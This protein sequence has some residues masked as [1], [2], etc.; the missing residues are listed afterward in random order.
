[1][2]NISYYEPYF[3]CNCHELAGIT[4]EK[5]LPSQLVSPF[6]FN[7]GQSCIPINVK[8]IKEKKKDLSF[9]TKFKTIK[10]Q[11]LIKLSLFILYTK[12]NS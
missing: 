2:F 7:L 10:G 8:L 6:S 4:A 9:F 12:T 1:M 11:Q 3:N 5:A